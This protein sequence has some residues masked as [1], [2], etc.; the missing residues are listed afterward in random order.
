MSLLPK[1]QFTLQ[2]Q[3]SEKPASGLWVRNVPLSVDDNVMETAL[4]K[5]GCEMRSTVRK[6]LARNTDVKL[7]S[8]PAVR[9]SY[10]PHNATPKICT[11]GI[12]SAELYHREIKEKRDESRKKYAVCCLTMR[13]A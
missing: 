9:L 12:L 4:N 11:V 2:N 1:T 6:E 10:R 7:S 5:L 13:F 3:N 8:W